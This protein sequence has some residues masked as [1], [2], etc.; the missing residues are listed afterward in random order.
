VAEHVDSTCDEYEVLKE[1]GIIDRDDD[2]LCGID[3][4][5]RLRSALS[6][7]D[8]M[9]WLLVLSRIPYEEMIRSDGFAAVVHVTIKYEDVA[10]IQRRGCTVFVLWALVVF[11]GLKKGRQWY[12]SSAD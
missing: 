1:T 5:E 7:N 2:S 11:G 3:V 8:V 6:V 12:L 4:V 10:E 9:R